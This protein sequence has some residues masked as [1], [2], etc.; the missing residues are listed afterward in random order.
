MDKYHEM[1][2]EYFHT[3]EGVKFY[4]KFLSLR[5]A[6]W[7]ITGLAFF[8]FIGTYLWFRTWPWLIPMYATEVLFILS[9]MWIDA[10]KW[11]R[12]KRRLK[13]RKDDPKIHLKEVQRMHLQHI[14]QKPAGSFAAV[15]KE[16]AD[17][18]ANQVR[19]SP[20]KINYWRLIY[21]PD[22]K[23]RLISITLASLALFVAL[24]SRTTDIELPSL[25]EFMAH[26]RFGGFLVDLVWIAIGLY[27]ICFG[28]YYAYTH[29]KAF[30]MSW[31]ARWKWELAEDYVLG[32]FVT[33]LVD[34]HAPVGWQ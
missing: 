1:A 18:K 25:L 21:D 17:L 15:V 24:V 12:Q 19:F 9:N 34:R 32:Y 14:T 30:V 22:S 28:I 26:E 11:N 7:F 29:I 27:A 33:A 8:T 20:P 31:L 10:F 5:W 13:L 16:V 2:A 23:A 4:P 6:C 3:F